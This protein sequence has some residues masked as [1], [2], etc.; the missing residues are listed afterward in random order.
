AS[1][2]K[3]QSIII[4]DLAYRIRMLE[5]ENGGQQAKIE[6]LE[7]TQKEINETRKTVS[8]E[9]DSHD[10]DEF[11]K[12]LENERARTQKATAA[13]E[14]NRKKYGDAK[15]RIRE[16]EEENEEK[17]RT[18]ERKNTEIA[19]LRRADR[20][21]REHEVVESRQETAMLNFVADRFRPRREA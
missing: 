11:D 19:R 4:K 17:N 21:A 20:T 9:I 10:V 13:A 5:L 12:A 18:I 1:F 2:D 3:A 6:K 16:L 14:Y 7:K 15:D 8:L